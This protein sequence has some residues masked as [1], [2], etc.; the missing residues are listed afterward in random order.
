[1][2]AFLGRAFDD[3]CHRAVVRQEVHVDR[4]DVGQRMAQ[5]PAKRDR[6]EEDF[7]KNHRRA[8]VEVHPAFH[9]CY[10][11]GELSKVEEG[12]GADS[13]P[14]RG[15]VHVDNIRPQ[16]D[17]DCDGNPK[18]RAGCQQADPKV[19]KLSLV[20]IDIATDRLAD[21]LSFFGSAH[22][23]LVQHAAGL[24]RHAETSRV[25]LRFHVL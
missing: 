15:R 23:R 24:L 22:D 7:R 18:P 13:G 1:M 25:D 8:Q 21:A 20:A 10:H 9:P 3:V 6:F 17:M 12:A 2:S 5:V 16:R 11:S 14:V 4:R 19:G